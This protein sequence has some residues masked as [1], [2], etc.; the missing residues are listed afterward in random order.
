MTKGTKEEESSGWNWG[1]GLFILGI[2]VIIVAGIIWAVRGTVDATVWTVFA[3]GIILL[4]IGIIWALIVS[5]E[6]K[7]KKKTGEMTEMTTIAHCPTGGGTHILTHEGGITSAAF[8][9]PSSR[10]LSPEEQMQILRQRQ[11]LDHRSISH[12]PPAPQRSLVYPTTTIG[13]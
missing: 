1:W 10:P 4:I 2:I 3:V 6:R 9:P 7:K 8:T 12:T 11:Q 5:G 13:C